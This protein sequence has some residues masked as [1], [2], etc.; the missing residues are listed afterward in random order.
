MALEDEHACL[1]DILE[2]NDGVLTVD[3][4]LEAAQDETSPLHKHF[5]WD[6]SKAAQEYRRWQA[7]SLIAK[8]RVVVESRPDTHVRAF[9]SLPSDRT[10]EGGGYRWRYDVLQDKDQTAELLLDMKN[11][12]AYW[13]RQATWLDKP[14]RKALERFSEAVNQATEAPR[15]EPA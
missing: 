10:Q 13:Q 5:T 6:D 12:I 9:V 3:A 1:N 2:E 4:V 14:T 15:P 7:R 11:R 8:C